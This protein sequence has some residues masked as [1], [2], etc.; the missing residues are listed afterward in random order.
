MLAL[1]GDRHCFAAEGMI[2]LKRSR[3]NLDRRVI[4]LNPSGRTQTKKRR[5]ILPMADW[6]AP[7]IERC[8]P[9]SSSSAGPRTTSRAR[10]ARSMKSPP[11][12]G[13]SPATDDVQAGR[14]S[15]VSPIP[16][17]CNETTSTSLIPGAGEGIRTLD[18]TLARMQNG[19]SGVSGGIREHYE[20]Y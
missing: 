15:S 4:D 1:L 6:L 18:P 12:S 17:L 14:V 3:C 19:Y 13:T 8:E 9:M 7:W 2:E 16:W 10:A 5:P 11:T 20:T